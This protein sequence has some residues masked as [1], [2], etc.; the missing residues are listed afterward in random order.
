MRQFLL[1]AALAAMPA[2]AIAAPLDPGTINRIADQS[3]SH[4]E[5]MQ[6]A[7]HLTDQIGGR[8]T[9]SPAMRE[10]ERWTQQQFRDWGP[11]QRP[12]RRLRFRPRLVDRALQRADDR[13]AAA[14]APRDPDRLDARH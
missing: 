14:A 4:S 5:V 9:N 7:A 3:F 10:A 12:P 13:A 11:H 1:I 6:T 8:L 2:S